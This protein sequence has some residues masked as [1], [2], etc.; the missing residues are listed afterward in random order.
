MLST[1]LVFGCVFAVPAL[2]CRAKEYITGDG[3]ALKNDAG[4]VVRRDCTEQSGTQC[5][6]CADG[7]FM[8]HPNGLNKCFPCTSCVPA[9]GLFSKQK[10]TATSDTVCDVLSGYFCKSLADDTGC[11]MAE[12]HTKCAPGQRTEQPG[13]EN[14]NLTSPAVE[15]LLGWMLLSFVS[16]SKE[17]AELI[18]CVRTVSQAI[19]HRMVSTAQLGQLGNWGSSGAAGK[20]CGFGLWTGLRSEGRRF[21]P[22]TKHDGIW[23]VKEAPPSATTTVV[24]LSK[25]PIHPRSLGAVVGSP[26]P[27]H[28][29]WFMYFVCVFC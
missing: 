9:L 12:K 21:V 25:A 6:P 24:P 10:C 18:Q 27:Q 17:P 13:K 5:I 16:F 15:P 28:L 7:T 4:T 23:E 26:L 20:E 1:L 29:Y 19:S 2:C 3:Q 14:S 22:S 8:N 11:I